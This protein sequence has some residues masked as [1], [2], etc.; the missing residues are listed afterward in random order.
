MLI[1]TVAPRRAF[2]RPHSRVVHAPSIFDEIWRGLR[3]APAEDAAGFVPLVDV[4]ETEE[5]RLFV[6][7][8]PGVEKGDFEVVVEDDVL[9]IK[10]RKKLSRP[11]EIA[12]NAHL[13][14]VGGEFSRSFRLPFEVDP[15]SVQGAYRDGVLT[16]TVPKP[17]PE[18][19]RT[20]PIAT[21]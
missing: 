8:L 2:R 10:G 12:T 6:A 16:V 3:T 20:I 14:R 11:T 19:V 1:H 18:P 21:D 5:S 4:S 17:A 7:E 13:E 9:T 15:D